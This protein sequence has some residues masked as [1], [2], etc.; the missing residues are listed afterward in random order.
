MSGRNGRGI[1]VTGAV[2]ATPGK[3]RPYAVVL[4]DRRIVLRSE[5][6]GSLAEGDRLLAHLLEELVADLAAWR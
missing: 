4:R 6:V 3:A 1:R 5:P 2:V